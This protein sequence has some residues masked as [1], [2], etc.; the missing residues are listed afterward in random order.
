MKSELPFKSFTQIF[1]WLRHLARMWDIQ[2]PSL[3]Q[4]RSEPHLPHD[5]HSHWVRSCLKVGHFLP[6]CCVWSL[7][8]GK[9]ACHT[10]ENP[11]QAAVRTLTGRRL[12]FQEPSRFGDGRY[13]DGCERG[14]GSNTWWQRRAGAAAAAAPAVEAVGPPEEPL[15]RCYHRA[16]GAH[17]G[18]MDSAKPT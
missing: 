13:R 8:D 1:L 16:G 18:R 2:P 9:G 10:R 7:K 14:A 4:R 15:A 3:Y 12:R 5:Y 17:L 6:C 11:P